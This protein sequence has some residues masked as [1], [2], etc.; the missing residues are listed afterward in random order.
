MHKIIE[1]YIIRFWFE[2]GG[3][4]LWSIN[5]N[6][7]DKYGYAIENNMLPI[8]LELVKRINELEEEYSSY[9]D[10][11]YPSNPSPWTKEHKQ[12]FINR[13][14]DVYNDLCREL[15]NNY[16]VINEVSYCC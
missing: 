12:D 4:C 14:T 15:G 6:A 7:K 11:D 13:A 1:K 3:I 2:N 8:S 5:Q 16:K 10:W 9:L